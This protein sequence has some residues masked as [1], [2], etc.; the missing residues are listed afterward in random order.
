M[1]NL[2]SLVEIRL[3]HGGYMPWAMSHRKVRPCGIQ[4][5]IRP[6]DRPLNLPPWQTRRLTPIVYRMSDL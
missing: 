3:L 2:L 4:G 5:I 1:M 6:N